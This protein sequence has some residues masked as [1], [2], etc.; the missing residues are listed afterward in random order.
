M[1]TDDL[2]TERV[3]ST[4]QDL[5]DDDEKLGEPN[6]DHAL[7][8]G[9]VYT[10]EDILEPLDVEYTVSSNGHV[11]EVT[12]VLCTGGPH[13]EVDCFDGTVRGYWGADTHK[14]HVRSDAV[15]DYGERMARMFEEN[16]LA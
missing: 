10:P 7:G 15:D 6:E 1:T 3:V 8:E 11:K 9:E 5:E 4:A 13:I 2:I 12:A 14:T 16:Y